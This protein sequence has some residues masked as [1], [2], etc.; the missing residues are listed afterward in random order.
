M[1]MLAPRDVGTLSGSLLQRSASAHQGGS[2]QTLVTAARLTGG[3]RSTGIEDYA[4]NT[5]TSP[6]LWVRLARLSV[7]ANSGC[8]RVVHHRRRYTWEMAN[9]AL[10][11]PSKRVFQRFC[12]CQ[13][14]SDGDLTTRTIDRSMFRWELWRDLQARIGAFSVRFPR[15]SLSW[16]QRTEIGEG[17]GVGKLDDGI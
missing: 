11:S 7:V 13:A 17:I 16:H 4:K 3:R 14:T 6:F 5:V 15:A 8:D 2:V 9:F 10:A 1:R 12:R